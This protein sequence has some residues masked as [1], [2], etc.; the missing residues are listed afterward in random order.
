[1][2]RS[3]IGAFDQFSRKRARSCGA[4]K[5]KKIHDLMLGEKKEGTG[6]FQVWGTETD[7]HIKK[8]KEKRVSQK[9]VAGQ[10]EGKSVCRVPKKEV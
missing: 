3:S 4:K 2:E 8:K 1:L 9:K 7:E 6:N 10:Q 5:K